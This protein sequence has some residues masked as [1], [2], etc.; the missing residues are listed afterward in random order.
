MF[1]LNVENEFMEMGVGL[2]F[3]FEELCKWINYQFFLLSCKMY[4][5]VSKLAQ[6]RTITALTDLLPLHTY[7]INKDNRCTY[8]GGKVIQG[9]VSLPFCMP[10][11][12]CDGRASF[13]PFCLMVLQSTVSCP[14]SVG[15]L[16]TS[17]FLPCSLFLF[18]IVSPGFWF[19]SFPWWLLSSLSFFLLSAACS[20]G[21]P[22]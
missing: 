9:S 14:T 11:P 4:F 8:R 15:L 19:W 16:S 18:R 22:W 12:P 17:T 21:V 5:L 13:V 20:K 1:T 10:G 6:R 7:I 2:H 3:D